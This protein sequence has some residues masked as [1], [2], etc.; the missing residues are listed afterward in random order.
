VNRGRST[1]CKL[2]LDKYTVSAL[3]RHTNVCT[4]HAY[5]RQSCVQQISLLF[6][7]ISLHHVNSNGILGHLHVPRKELRYRLNRRMGKMT[8][9]GGFVEK[10]SPLPLRGFKHRTVHPVT[11]RRKYLS[12][13]QSETTVL[14]SACRGQYCTVPAE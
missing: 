4:E 8:G 13:C 2:C 5:G 1:A 11:A 14:L 9:F 10:N 7:S 12:R 6:C 3:R